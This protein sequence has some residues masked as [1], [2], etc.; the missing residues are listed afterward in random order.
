MQILILRFSNRLSRCK[1]PNPCRRSRSRRSWPPTL[2]YLLFKTFCFCSLPEVPAPWNLCFCS[3]PERL[4]VLVQRVLWG[5]C[6]L[7]SCAFVV[8]LKAYKCFCIMEWCSFKTW[9]MFPGELLKPLGGRLLLLHLDKRP[10]KEA[11]AQTSKEAKNEDFWSRIKPFLLFSLCRKMLFYYPWK[12]EGGG[13]VPNLIL[14]AVKST[15]QTFE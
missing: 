4:Q 15:L 5:S 9:C 10:E 7:K 3:L 8:F 13:I 12:I 1:S 2:R 14:M 6:S 11:A